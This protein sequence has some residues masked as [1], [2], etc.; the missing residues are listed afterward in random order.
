MENKK[1]ASKISLKHLARRSENH[2]VK[3]FSFLS[4][5]LTPRSRSAVS[6]VFLFLLPGLFFWRESLGLATLGDKDAIFWF[7]PAYKF[8]AE[9]LRQGHLPLITPYIYCGQPFLA[10][11]APAVFD[12]INWIYLVGV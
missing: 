5:L 10:E 7:F 8:V 9:Q 2:K 12:P 1:S 3:R 4:P 11:W 6:I